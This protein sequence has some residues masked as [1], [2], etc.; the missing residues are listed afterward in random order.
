MFMAGVGLLA[1]PP[2]RA[3][4]YMPDG[5]VTID[6]VVSLGEGW[7]I[8][9]IH[10]G[11]DNPDRTRFCYD[12]NSAA[13]TETTDPSTCS[14]VLF[15]ES[16]QIDIATAWIG[17]NEENMYLAYKSV[18]PMHT[19]TMPD[20]S[21]VSLYDSSQLENLGV[22]A[23]PNPFAH[24][25]VF[26]FDVE[27][28]VGEESYDWYMAA[29]V[30]YDFGTGI[31]PGQ[32]P[33]F[34]QIYQEE[35]T[36]PGYQADED[37]AVADLSLDEAET[38]NT[39]DPSQ[40]DPYFEV[41]MNIELFYETTG[42]QVGDHVGFRL[43][44]HSAEG[45][46]TDQVEVEFVDT[47]VT[48]DAVVVGNGAR[49]FSGRNPERYGR[50]TFKVYSDADQS[51]LLSVVA[52]DKNVGVQ[53]ATGDVDADGEIEIVTLPFKAQKNPML[54]VFNL[55]GE[56]E[57][58]SRIPTDEGDRLTS[59]HMAVGNLDTSGKEEIVLA[60]GQGAQLVI[61]VLR[62]GDDDSLN[63][64]NQYVEEARSGYTHGAWVKV[65]NVITDTD[66]EEIVTAP[67][68][69]ESMVELWNLSNDV[70]SLTASYLEIEADEGYVRGVHIAPAEGG[71]WIIRR[72]A[73]Q[74][75]VWHEWVMAKGNL[76]VT[77]T[78]MRAGLIGDAVAS[79]DALWISRFTGRTVMKRTND[80]EKEYSLDITTK[81][82]FLDLIDV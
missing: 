19:L 37:T 73:T 80:G 47:A 76:N 25:F 9:I 35:G 78:E 21:F 74:K 81:G 68:K 38:A 67:F 50:G 82:S 39:T 36:T 53:V 3:D 4:F 44:T 58:S 69:G 48:E 32:N 24:D 75:A 62:L 54:K 34:M 70:V 7:G 12:A 1:A 6:N 27:P 28:E 20:E 52:Y 59:Y 15:D 77:D 22:S 41:R 11:E 45:D 65:A 33:S 8:P 23:L 31:G 40:V 51:E 18:A 5:Q 17:F 71:V 30:I 42:I 49:Q 60:N 43:E 2:A 56:L 61:D 79:N 13:W 14:T 16:G 63:R 57:T 64:V 46:E 29:H 55:N 26:S 66:A 72:G 10:D